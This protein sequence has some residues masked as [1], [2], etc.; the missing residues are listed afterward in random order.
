VTAKV[1]IDAAVTAVQATLAD[2]ASQ[3]P[4]VRSYPGD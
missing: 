4:D 2:Q 1:A 3:S